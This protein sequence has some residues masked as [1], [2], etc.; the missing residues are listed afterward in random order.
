MHGLAKGLVGRAVRSWGGLPIPRAT[1][2]LPECLQGAQ[3]WDGNGSRIQ[4]QLR[5]R[6]DA[7]FA[8]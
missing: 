3:V 8:A 1:T 5:G 2:V 6:N 4:I 7:A